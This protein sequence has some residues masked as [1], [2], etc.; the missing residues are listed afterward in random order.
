MTAWTWPLAPGTNRIRGGSERNT[1]G[2]VRLKIV[3]GKPVPKAHQGWD[4]RADVGTPF[5]AVCAGVVETVEDRGALGRV[6]LLRCDTPHPR[7]GARVYALYAHLQSV[8]VEVGDRVKA[9]TALGLTGNSG[10]AEGLDD[11][12]DHLHFE[13]RTPEPWPGLGL[14]GRCTPLDIFGRCPLKEAV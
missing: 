11:S 2:M 3:N 7:T 4:F 9:G 12:E 14:A 5:F 1:F 6:L 10:N 13:I 8:V